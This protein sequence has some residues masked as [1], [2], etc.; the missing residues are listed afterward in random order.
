MKIIQPLHLIF[1]IYIYIYYT[2]FIYIYIIVIK[3]IIVHAIYVIMEPK[4]WTKGN[5]KK[6]R[7]HIYMYT[8]THTHIYII[9]G[10]FDN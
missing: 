3:Y 1:D 9:H 5:Y 2:N 6:G 10:T 7:S 4:S 8:H